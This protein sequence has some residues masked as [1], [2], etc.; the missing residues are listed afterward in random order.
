MP[1]ETTGPVKLSLEELEGMVKQVPIERG[2]KPGLVISSACHNGA[3][4]YPVYVK[5]SGELALMCTYCRN[6][7]AAVPVARATIVLPRGNG[8]GGR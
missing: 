3:P 8:M 5:D 4:V 2:Q 1:T 7:F 6:I